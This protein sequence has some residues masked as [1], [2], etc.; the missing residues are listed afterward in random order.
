[1]ECF[2]CTRPWANCFILIKSFHPYDNPMSQVHYNTN[3]TDDETRADNEASNPSQTASKWWN[4]SVNSVQSG[5][6]VMFL[7]TTL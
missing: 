2:P 6:R 5:S 1:M 4:Q 3:F 7:T